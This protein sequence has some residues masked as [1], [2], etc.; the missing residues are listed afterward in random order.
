MPQTPALTLTPRRVWDKVYKMPSEHRA[1]GWAAIG[2]ALVAIGAPTGLGLG[3]YGASS[4]LWGHEVFLAGF[5]LACVLTTIGVYVLIAEFIGGIGPLR[6]PLPPTRLEREASEVTS[7]APPTST[8]PLAPPQDQVLAATQDPRQPLFD[9]APPELA[10]LSPASL[11]DSFAG[12]T[13]AQGDMLMAQHVGKPVCVSG[14]VEGVELGLSG[15]RIPAVTL[16]SA[17]RLL[18][19]FDSDEDYD[20]VPVV[21]ALHEGD[22]IVVS[23]QIHKLTAEM[24]S[25]EN[26]KLVEAGERPS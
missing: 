1:T 23:G 3:L 22:Q 25:L 2:G 5:I 24:V 10:D 6:F 18:L 9:Q 19:F 16:K 12:R 8:P 21:L 7:D 4:H 11:R 20:P 13:Q 14:E 17:M 15:S 26:C